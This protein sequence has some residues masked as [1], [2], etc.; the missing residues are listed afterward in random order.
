MNNDILPFKLS[1]CAQS[2]CEVSLMAEKEKE[3]NGVM[4]DGRNHM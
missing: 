4:I 1:E 3:V 2:C